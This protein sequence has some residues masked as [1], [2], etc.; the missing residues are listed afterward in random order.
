MTIIAQAAAT[1]ILDSVAPWATLGVTGIVS[2]LLVWIITRGL[3]KMRDD[4]RQAMALIVDAFR[5]ESRAD[6][7]TIEHIV[8]AFRLERKD[9][10]ESLHEA[11][12]SFN[13]AMSH[14]SELLHSVQKKKEIRP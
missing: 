1:P 2:W 6:R 5:Q 11:R 10:R 8:A 14:I 9:D 3:P 12:K 7:E 4:D 13:D